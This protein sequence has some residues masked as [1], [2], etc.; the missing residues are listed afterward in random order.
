[1]TGRKGNGS[2]EGRAPY[3]PD[4]YRLESAHSG[5]DVVLL[6]QD[7]SKVGIFGPDE[8]SHAENRAF[9]DARERSERRRR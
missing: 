2:R 4:G 5:G 9:E 6:R 3:L 8:I 1:M 7:G